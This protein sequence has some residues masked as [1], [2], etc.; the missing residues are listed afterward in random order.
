MSPD[1][2]AYFLFNRLPVAHSPRRPP[3]W[4]QCQCL[5]EREAAF[6]CGG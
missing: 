2:G 6:E 5:W 1:Q 4:A 3:L